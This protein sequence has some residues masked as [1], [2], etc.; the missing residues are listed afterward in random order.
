MDQESFVSTNILSWPIKLFKQMGGCDVDMCLPQALSVRQASSISA[1]FVKDGVRKKSAKK[2]A[3]SW[4][5]RDLFRWLKLPYDP[6]VVELPLVKRQSR[7]KVVCEEA[8]AMT[9]PTD[10]ICEMHKHGVF[11]LTIYGPEGHSSLRSYW[12]SEDPCWLRKAGL[13]GR[14]LS[15]CIPTFW[16]EDSVPSFKDESYNFFSW[17]SLSELG[18]FQSRNCLVG[19]PSSRMVARTRECIVSVIRWNMEALAQGIHPTCDHKGNPWPSGSLRAARAGLPLAHPFWG[20]FSA[21][22]GDQEARVLAHRLDNRHYSFLASDM[23]WQFIVE[24]AVLLRV[25]TW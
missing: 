13:Y 20:V 17:G 18:A 19:L 11:H 2:L 12:A 14:D 7:D 22:Q 3:K 8:V 21:W 24:C 9:L 10:L 25:V 6:Y 15:N 4:R 1:A 23:L 5:N 16:H